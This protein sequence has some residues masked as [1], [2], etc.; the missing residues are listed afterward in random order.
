MARVSA[1]LLMYRRTPAGL[2]VFLAHP[3]GPYFA[4]K[5]DGVWTI[6]KGEPGADEDLLDCARRE[7]AE[8]TGLVPDAAEYVALGQVR[9][10]G[11]KVVHAWAFAGEWG[12]RALRC[13]P[14]EVEWPPRSGRR[15]SFPEIDRAAFFPLDAA[16][17][18]INPAQ[19]AL[20]DRLTAKLD[21][22]A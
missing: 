19:V 2:E 18:K 20:L 7:F 15:Q 5:D 9:Q 17:R 16:R 12:E 13:N 8:E 1:G 4:N 10:R 22:P 21:D 6:P 14:F 3:G 11:G